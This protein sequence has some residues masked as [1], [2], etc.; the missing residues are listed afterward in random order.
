MFS[1]TKQAFAVHD[2]RRVT[3]PM[4]TPSSG[5][6]QLRSTIDLVRRRRRIKRGRKRNHPYEIGLRLSEFDL[7]TDRQSIQVGSL[8][9][10]SQS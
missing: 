3:T 10:V 6:T 2:V 8:T 1:K 4:A 5:S 7:R 9:F